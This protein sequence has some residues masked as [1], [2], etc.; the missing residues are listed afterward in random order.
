MLAFLKESLSLL[1]FLHSFYRLSEL[2]GACDISEARAFIG[3]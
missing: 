1:L 3:S 2:E